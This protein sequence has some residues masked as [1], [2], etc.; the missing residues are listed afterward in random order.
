MGSTRRFFL[1]SVLAAAVLLCSLV[2]PAARGASGQ[3]GGQGNASSLS[4]LT[5][6]QTGAY[7]SSL[8][9]ADSATIDASLIASAGTVRLGIYPPDGVTLNRATINVS[10]RF[11]VSGASV[12]VRCVLLYRNAAGTYIITGASDP[13]TL[14]AGAAI[15]GISSGSRYIA[16]TFPFDGAGANYCL[17]QLA[18]A[19]SSGNVTLFVGTV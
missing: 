9:S 4:Y 14:T 13:I 5:D 19:V 17:I 16:P 10:A 6:A 7:R 8:S 15:D 2:A 12:S 1:A 11:S 3:T 18:G